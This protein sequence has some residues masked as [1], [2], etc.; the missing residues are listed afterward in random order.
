VGEPLPDFA[1]REL[2]VEPAGRELNL[3]HEAGG[4]P[5]LLVFVHELNRPSI[6]F[7]RALTR[8]AQSRR[9]DGLQTAVI[10][11]DADAT[12]AEANLKRIQ[13]ALTPN[14]WTGVS[15]DGQEGPGSYGL[16]RQ[17]QLT[18]LIAKDNVVTTNLALTQPSLPTDLPEAL[19]GIVAVIGGTPPEVSELVGEESKR[20]ERPTGNQPNLRPLLQP[21]LNKNATD[22]EIVAAAETVER[23][24]ADDVAI[25]KELGR[26]CRSIVDGGVLSNYGTAKTQ[27]YFAKWAELYAE[28]SPEPN[29]P[30]DQSR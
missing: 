23:T 16:N 3:V 21:M 28:K 13:H 1:F 5:V 4:R 24:A 29:K 8:Y 7:T 17:V 27:E 11:L 14:V 25:R 6:G 18:I 20:G 22:E 19:A 30:K 10:L 12:A 15:L 2:L 9:A 26:A